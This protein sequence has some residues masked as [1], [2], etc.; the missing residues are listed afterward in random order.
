M[1]V[2]IVCQSLLLTRALELFLKNSLAPYKKCDFVICDKKIDLN[3]PQFIISDDEDADLSVPFLKSALIL[4]LEEFY[5]KLRN[6][7][8]F[9]AKLENG[10]KFESLEIKIDHLTKQ[11]R[12]ELIKTIKEYYEE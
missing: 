6:E 10:R 3:K 11:F 9:D 4:K 1:R 7:E 12:Q 2:S 5:K 8:S